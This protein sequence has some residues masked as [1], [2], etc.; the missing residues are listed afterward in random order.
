MAVRRCGR[1]VGAC[2]AALP[3]TPPCLTMS[4]LSFGPWRLSAHH[5]SAIWTQSEGSLCSSAMGPA[6][7]R[8][9]ARIA[10]R[11]SHNQYRNCFVLRLEYLS[12]GC[13]HQKHLWYLLDFGTP[14]QSVGFYRGQ[15]ELMPPRRYRGKSCQFP[16][17]SETLGQPKDNLSKALHYNLLGPSLVCTVWA[18]E[19]FTLWYMFKFF[20]E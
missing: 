13:I 18:G 8:V 16:G 17:S 1:L 4:L 2:R 11:K 9:A 10:T 7:P 5:S 6:K 14:A 19:I 20:I 15:L 3:E 12:T